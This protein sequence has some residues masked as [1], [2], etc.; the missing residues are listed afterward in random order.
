[1]SPASLRQ[2]VMVCLLAGALAG[3]ASQPPAP[4]ITPDQVEAQPPWGDVDN[5]T[6]VSRLYFSAQPDAATFKAARVNG[7]DVVI[8]LREPGETDYDEA[9]DAAQAGLVYYQVPVARK[10]QSLDADA[11]ARIS[12][13]VRQ[14][15]GQRML[16]H[17]R[18][19]QRA[20]SWL[21]VHLAE[22]HGM[23]VEQSLEVAGAAGLTSETLIERV[24]RYLSQP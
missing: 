19:G 11:M 15:P 7:V 2:L 16:L 6:R 10:G 24:Q 4:A 17:C 3:C 8:N 5:V 13:L 14:H 9:A 20:T 18:T 23:T 1:M 12:E 22:D 21:A